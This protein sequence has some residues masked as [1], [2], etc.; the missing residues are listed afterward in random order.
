MGGRPTGEYCCD[1]T[2]CLKG[3]TF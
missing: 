2:T 3:K 1:E